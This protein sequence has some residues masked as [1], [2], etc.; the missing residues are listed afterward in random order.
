MSKIQE[1]IPSPITTV[2]ICKNDIHTTDDH[3]K[4]SKQTELYDVYAGDICPALK[5]NQFPQFIQIQDGY[6]FQQYKNDN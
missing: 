4:D 1:L 6:D 2:I 5:S 3:S